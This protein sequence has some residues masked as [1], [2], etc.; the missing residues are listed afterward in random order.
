[1]TKVGASERGKRTSFKPRRPAFRLI[2]WS[3]PGSADL[4]ANTDAVFRKGAFSSEQFLNSLFTRGE[5]NK[6]YCHS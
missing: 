6:V 4:I 1:M 3:F 5:E 2:R